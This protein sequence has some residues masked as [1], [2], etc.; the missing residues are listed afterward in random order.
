[1][2]SSKFRRPIYS[3][4]SASAYEYHSQ[5]E[6]LS[7]AP[8]WHF[9]QSL[10]AYKETPLIPLDALAESIG[11][12][13]ILV[14]DET[15]RLNLPSFKSLGASWGIFRA[16]TKKLHLPLHTPLAEYREA[17]K[18]RNLQLFA[19]TKGNHGRAVARVA[20]I[21]HLKA[22]I[23]V[24]ADV[25]AEV[26]ELIKQLGADVVE[27]PGSYDEAIEAAA[28]SA[29]AYDGALI[30]DTAF[31][32]YEEVPQWIVDG[33]I[34]ML[35]EIDQELG[36]K[37]PDVIIVPVGVGS[38]AQAVVSHYKLFGHH[39]PI[40]I[41]TVEPDIAATLYRSLSSSTNAPIDV[42]PTIM[43]GLCCE[44]VSHL[45]WPIL[46][47]GVDASLTVS[48]FEAH[49][50]VLQ[51]KSEGINAGPCGA[52]T[53]AALLHIAETRPTS[54]PL[55]PDS[56]VVLLCTEGDRPYQ[57]PPDVSIDDPVELCQA[58]VRID[59]S[60]PGLSRAGGAGET[61]I[62]SFINAWLQHRGIETH[63][64]EEVPGR[65]SVVGIVRGSGGGKSLM[66]NGHVDTVSTASYGRNPLSGNIVNG[67]LYGRGAADM[68]SG[69]AAALVALAR[70][71][72]G[73]PL[74]GDVIIAAVAD[75]ENTSIG[76]EQV[77]KAGWKAD[78]A[79]VCE[80]TDLA[81][82]IMHKGFIWFEI[83]IHGTAAHGSRPD[84]GVDAIVKA[85]YLLVELDKYNISLTTAKPK[86]AMLGTGSV[87]AG[88]IQGG[89]EPSSY[90]AK[91]TV[92]V[93]RRTI[94]GETLKKVEGEIEDILKRL[95]NSDKTFTY[96]KRVTLSRTPFEISSKHRFV[97]TALT[98]IEKVLQT[99]PVVGS[100]TAWTDCALLAEAGIS[101]LLF[102]PE[103]KGLH[104]EKE[105]ATV[106]SILKTADVLTSLASDFCA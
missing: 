19:A 15:S 55:T 36:G 67:L 44:T 8:T 98:H 9:H 69:L 96:T 22:T 101:P 20:G 60:N 2:P 11:V 48:D 97:K 100:M 45:A 16:I 92:T 28:E 75:E 31:E 29:L 24:P 70:I 3:N 39:D 40:V 91:C 27:F 58:L 46:Q 37:H 103:G 68:K 65:P 23:F 7:R 89:E 13:R 105:W 12:K 21:L 99:P 71:K 61:E 76:T 81:P 84:L 47:G 90:P 78:A 82:L 30:Q 87:H 5:L 4:P 86:S 52:A 63:W 14:K 54:V 43:T 79:V 72:T 66:F 62:A 73:E 56:T 53:L 1:M 106:D 6:N 83:D 57:I 74:K 93:E 17:A 77:L 10:G 49:E 32:G 80:P 88:L 64:I 38:L 18:I 94:P 35:L 85:G 51:F 41:V 34:T 102:G 42:F 59:S 50:A 26:R 25:D 95:A 33:Y 104:S